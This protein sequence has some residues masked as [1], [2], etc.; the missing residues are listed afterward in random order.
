VIVSCAVDDMLAAMSSR[1]VY[2]GSSV[3]IGAF[4]SH[5]GDRD[6]A[7]SGP[8][9]GHLLVFPRTSVTITHA[10]RETVVADPTVVMIYNRGQEYRRG[11]VS[12]VGD[13]CE[14]FAYPAEAVLEARDDPDGDHERPFGDIMRAPSD[15]RSY[16]LASL[17]Y[18]HVG[19]GDVDP[20]LVEEATANLLDHVMS[21]SRPASVSRAHAALADATRRVLVSRF[22]ERLSLEA[23]ALGVGVSAFHLARVF[24]RATGS[25]IHAHRTQ[26][27]LHAA[28][29]RLADTHDLAA[30]A[31]DLGFSSHSHFTSTFRSSL[32]V[33]PSQ[34]QRDPRAVMAR[35][36]A[37][38]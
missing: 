21:R 24:R 35:L 16:L 32:G 14:W 37:R 28:V 17:A 19:G 36:R 13:R 4:R 31:L 12:P 5:P 25:T 20:L 11:A 2:T 33:T 7:D 23:L 10:D 38:S 6:F 34:V 30:L 9:R 15:A 8:T 1:V 3:R 22:A 26:L 18:A 27:R 29:E